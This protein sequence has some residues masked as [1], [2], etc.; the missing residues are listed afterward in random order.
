MRKLAI[1]SA[2]YALAVFGAT[3]VLPGG[4]LLPL[5][6][7][8]AVLAAALHLLK[9]ILPD[10]I[11]RRALICCAGM[12]LGFV[13]TWGYDCLFLEPARAMDDRTVVLSGTVTDWPQETDYGASVLMQA[14][15]DS[16]R[17][18]LTLLYIDRE[19]MHLQPGD[20]ISTI[21]HCTVA[22]RTTRGDEITYYTAKGI[23]LTAKAYGEIEL[24]RPDRMP[25][26]HWPAQLTRALKQGIDNS[27]SAEAAPF[28]RAVV[29]GN[30]DTLSDSYTSSLQRTGLSHAVAVSGMHLAY[31]AGFIFLLLGRGKR[32]TALLGIPMILLFT[33][34]AGCT[35]SVVRAA[36]M[37]ILL[38]IAPLLGRER[39]DFTALAFAL[40]LLL[41]HNPYAA[42]SVSLQ[43]SF[44]SVLGIILFSEGL[45]D[46]I[47]SCML[48]DCEDGLLCRI[49][50]RTA[51]V[52][53]SAFAATLGA[54]SLTV[55]LTA[56]YFE[57]VSLI[58]PVSN[59]LILW[60]VSFVFVG[61]LAVGM[62]GAVWPVVGS[63]LALMVQPFVTYI[64][65]VIHIL[66]RIPFAAIPT[67]TAFY[68]MWLVFLY[69][70]LALGIIIPG[71]KR[72]RLP[73]AAGAVTLVAAIL[74]TNLAFRAGAMT[75]QVLDVGQGQ[76]VLIRS[77]S[78]L[79]LVDCGGDSYRNAGDIAADQIQS[80]G[81]NS[82]D[83]LVISHYHTDHAN[84]IP[85]LLE[86]IDVKCIALPEDAEDSVL[87]RRIVEQ[88]RE[89]DIEL[90]YVREDT[91]LPFGEDT[92]F[93]IY[94]PVG[95][96]GTN[97]LG[98]TVL[99]SAGDYDVLLTGDMGTS[100][101]KELVAYTE[102]PDVELMVAGHHGSKYAN[103]KLLLETVRPD[104]AVFSVGED[105][106]YGHPTPE[107]MERFRAV[108]AQIY[109]TDL[110]GTVT[111][112]VEPDLTWG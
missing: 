43:M 69:G 98:L 25:L 105:N 56:F 108:G 3:L 44:G 104:V 31:L 37:V 63:A 85:E 89:R 50:N 101:E 16:V 28:V 72:L 80:F 52:V 29:T 64:T 67:T 39:D 58:A 55:P 48:R 71:R 15:L 2:G 53:A 65:G 66:A 97:E 84:G 99:C 93:T 86:R 62:L 78:H 92:V 112:T 54:V 19:D 100:V 68:R 87:H 4:V 26:S 12:V 32:V 42:A 88:V 95:S 24:E 57:Q 77:G 6:G 96:E 13:W 20:R 90:V 70:L 107:A 102:L 23:G 33:V 79:A 41:L 7:F 83:L 109:R 49:W 111:I 81:Y 74:F 10:K 38:Q 22:T 17:S 76:S 27:F 36:I 35:P 46:R 18:V 40:L 61:G 82:I 75:V 59:L 103:S 60:A 21:A 45:R 73:V 11:R 14:E 8:C 5:G 30:R 1:F 91:S 94:P 51:R 47:L 110:M 106:S 9:K 34:V